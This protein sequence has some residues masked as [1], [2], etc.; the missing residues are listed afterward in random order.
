L[1]AGD[2]AVGV[3]VPLLVALA[4][5]GPD[6]DFGAVGGAVAVG[7]EAVGG[8]VD[9]EGELSGG[10]V[11]PVLVGLAVA[12][13]DLLLGAAG[14]R[15][16]RVVQALARTHRVQRTTRTATGRGRARGG[17]AAAECGQ[18]RGESGLGLV[19][20]VV[21]RRRAPPGEGARDPRVGV[22]HAPLRD[23]H[24]AGDGQAVP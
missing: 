18:C 7:V 16:V 14:G 21:H 5:A 20:A 13:V 8:A 4:V 11:G 15:G 12:V 22:A 2:G 19:V 23:A 10:G 9:G 1:D 17:S 6:V 24:A 3:E